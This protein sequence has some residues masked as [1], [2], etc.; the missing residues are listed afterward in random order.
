MVREN[1]IKVMSTKTITAGAD[2]TTNY[3]TAT[4]NTNGPVNGLLQAV[5]VDLDPSATIEIYNLNASGTTPSLQVLASGTDLI[6]PRVGA[7]GDGGAAI[8]DS[9]VEYVLKGNVG[10]DVTNIKAGSTTKVE[11]WYM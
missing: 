6:Y 5:K 1:R 4:D 11:L 2:L 9:A 10:V 8:S 3:S 7:V